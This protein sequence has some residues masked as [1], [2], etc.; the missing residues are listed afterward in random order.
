MGHRI[1]F[2]FVLATTF[3]LCFIAQTTGAAQQLS[4]PDK[5]FLSSLKK[6]IDTRAVVLDDETFI[7][8]HTLEVADMDLSDKQHFFIIKVADTCDSHCHA[9]FENHFDSKHYEILNND[10]AV[11]FAHEIQIKN[12][13]MDSSDISTENHKQPSI[14]SY[15]VMS[16]ET[17][18]SAESLSGCHLY[19]EQKQKMT[20]N[21]EEVNV[22]STG[23][24]VHNTLGGVSGQNSLNTAK[25]LQHNGKIIVS[26]ASLSETDFQVFI[27][28][29]QTLVSDDVVMEFNDIE[30]AKPNQRNYFQFT[31]KKVD[32]DCSFTESIVNKLSEFREIQRVE[33]APEIQLFNRWAKPVCQSGVSTNQA[34]TI[35]GALDGTNQTVGISDTG[36]DMSS[37]YFSDTAVEAPY[38]SSTQGRVDEK[39]RKVVQYISYADRNDDTSSHGTHVAGSICGSSVKDYGDFEKFNGVAKNAKIAFFDI[40]NGGASLTLPSNV[41]S[42]MYDIQYSAGARVFSESWGNSG[43]YYTSLCQQSDTFM[44]RN[45]EALL[46]Y[47]GGNSGDTG[48]SG[49]STL[50]SPAGAKNVL[51]VGATLNEENVFRA[52][53]SSVPDGVDSR[54]NP[55]SLAYFSSQGPTTDGRLKPDVTAPGWWV[56]SA[57]GV[58]GNTNASAAHCTL[59]TLQGTSM[60]TPIVA[61][62]V[63]MVRQYFMQ[64]FYPTG[65]KNASTGFRPA[66]ALLK[67]MMIHSSQALTSI[68][69]VDPSSGATSQEIISSTS[70][71]NSKAG[72]GRIQIDK[73]LN[74]GKPTGQTAPNNPLSL[75]V[76]GASATNASTVSSGANIYDTNLYDRCVSGGSTNHEFY[77]KT[78][79][80]VE[81]LRVTMVYTDYP[82]TTTTSSSTSSNLINSLDLTLTP[83]GTGSTVTGTGNGNGVCNSPSNVISPY[84]SSTK[85]VLMIDLA[86]PTVSSIYKVTVAC[87]TITSAY[88]DFS[89]VMSQDLTEY[90]ANAADNPWAPYVN[91]S[92]LG[93]S[94]ISADAGMIIAV[95]SVIA[96]VLGLVV[97]TIYFSHKEADKLEKE[98]IQA[99]VHQLA[100][101]HHEMMQQGNAEMG[102]GAGAGARRNDNSLVPHQQ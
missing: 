46:L 83:C 53:A 88:Q 100:R 37:C 19:N 97:M 74:F 86:A 41:Q 71:P 85:P 93:A 4:N 6:I 79:S 91:P 11:V 55:S 36:I 22:D 98:E 62:N 50:G 70:Y 77:F 30:L 78:G 2:Q 24:Q 32:N 34:I 60:A 28:K 23:E 44:H 35:Q 21:G 42:G 7:E 96:F 31:V 75:F 84:S 27:D 26:A 59:T 9:Y 18:I 10:L 89:L 1:F 66:G 61:G 51:T 82:G 45:N 48:S 63:L 25:P 49:A 52:F 3:V 69:K 95:F 54:F 33:R 56:T 8:R 94:F 57:A 92:T 16:K 43:N 20:N 102:M 87:T 68:M 67:A 90:T 101:R 39:H 13:I 40:S 80:V 73:V 81:P 12:F 29:L 64:G 47:A 5:L 72:Y 99:A 76:V 14:L 65:T 15:T 17:K 58:S 38:S